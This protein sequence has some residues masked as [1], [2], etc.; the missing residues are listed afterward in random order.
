MKA[1]CNYF[2][3]ASQWESREAQISRSAGQWLGM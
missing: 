1:H 2:R 3:R